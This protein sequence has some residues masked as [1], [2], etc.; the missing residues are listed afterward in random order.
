[1]EHIFL[2]SESAAIVLKEKHHKNRKLMRSI[3]EF[4]ICIQ[5]IQQKVTEART[6]SSAANQKK[7][8]AKCT[9][10]CERTDSTRILRSHG[11]RAKLRSAKK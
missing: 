10:K 11:Q 6:T 8:D 3:A 5:A 2:Y 7:T 9:K 4:E 1:M